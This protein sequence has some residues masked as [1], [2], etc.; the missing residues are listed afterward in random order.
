MSVSID[1]PLIACATHQKFY[2]FTHTDTLYNTHAY[3]HTYKTRPTYKTDLPHTACTAH[4]FID[5]STH[6]DELHITQTYISHTH[7][8]THI[9]DT[10]HSQQAHI[11]THIHTLIHVYTHPCPATPVHLHIETQRQTTCKVET[12]VRLQPPHP[13]HNCAERHTQTAKYTK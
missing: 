13:P 3:I 10:L 8:Y 1:M 12:L 5:I 2:S 6:G 4:R 11:H 9:A 7:T